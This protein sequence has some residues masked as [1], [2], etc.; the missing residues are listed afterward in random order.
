MPAESDLVSVTVVARKGTLTDILSTA[1]FLVGSD[2]A[3]SLAA[4]YDASIL[5]VKTDGTLLVS[6]ALADT[7]VPANG[8]EP[9]YR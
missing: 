4:E 6:A 5:A 8:W 3:F 7:F 1:C 2:M 9:I